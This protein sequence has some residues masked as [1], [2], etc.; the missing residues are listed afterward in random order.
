MKYTCFA[1]IQIQKPVAHTGN[2]NECLL[3][4]TVSARDLGGVEGF[5]ATWKPAQPWPVPPKREPHLHPQRLAGGCISSNPMSHG[6]NLMQFG[7]I[8]GSLAFELKNSKCSIILCPSLSLSLFFS[9]HNCPSLFFQRAFFSVCVSC[10]DILITSSKSA[11]A[12]FMVLG[13]TF[14]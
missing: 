7:D 5:R 8:W 4:S 12:W 2:G 3:A 1:Q 10:H 13:V 11:V 9:L 6:G 14:I